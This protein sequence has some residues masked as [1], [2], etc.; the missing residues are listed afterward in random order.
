MILGFFVFVVLT[1]VITA[2]DNKAELSADKNYKGQLK[3]TKQVA[4]ER[5]KK[6]TN[7]NKARS[8]DGEKGPD[9]EQDFVSFVDQNYNERVN[10]QLE[11]VINR[12]NKLEFAY[13]AYAS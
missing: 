4:V 13:R 8:L 9:G 11:Q 6:R 1:S 10:K 7:K 3:G 5:L 12:Y 2:Q